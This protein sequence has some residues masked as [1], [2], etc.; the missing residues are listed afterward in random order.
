MGLRASEAV[1]E[2][3]RPL[4]PAQL[5]A[6]AVGDGGDKLPAQAELRAELQGKLLWRVLPLR[7][8]PLKL[9]HQRDVPNVDV[10]L[11]NSRTLDER[12]FC[13]L[14]HHP[15]GCVVSCW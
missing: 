9:V 14:K 4:V 6:D 13:V 10:Q 1:P 12:L 3:V 2:G 11:E 15:G 7:H 5:T 8:V